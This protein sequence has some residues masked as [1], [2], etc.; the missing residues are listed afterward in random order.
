[1]ELKMRSFSV[2]SD[3]IPVGEFKT[4]MAQWLKRVQ[5]TGHPLVIT[6]NGK[7]AGVLLSPA[8]YDDLVE[9]RLLL[10]SVER[11]ISDIEEGRHYTGKEMKKEILKRR[12]KGAAT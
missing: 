7:P 11:G 10:E 1:M 12:K 8:E 3:I 6:Q 4:G 5:E 2:L 9:R